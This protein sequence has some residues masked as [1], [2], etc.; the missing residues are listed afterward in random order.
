MSTRKRPRIARLPG[1]PAGTL[2][3]EEEQQREEEQVEAHPSYSALEV[4]RHKDFSE[5]TW[6]EV[7]AAKAALAAM[8]WPLSA[9]PTRRLRSAAGGRQLDL[10]RVIR[11]NLRY[12]GEP[13]TLRW[14]ERKTRCRPLVILCDISGSMERYSRMLLHFLHALS[15]TLGTVETFV[16]GTRLTRI[17]HH[18]RHRDVDDA[19]DEVG[20]IVQDWSGGTKIGQAIKSFNYEW[21]RRVLGRGAVVLIISDGWDRGEVDV[22]AHAIGRLQRAAHRLIWLNP[23]LGSESYEPIQRGMAAAL[24]FVDDF[25]PVHNLKSLEQ[26]AE[27]LSTLSDRRPER[28][29][30]PRLQ[31]ASSS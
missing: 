4:L 20:R 11:D 18:L 21:A 2:S 26:L 13:L 1:L 25:L 5:M 3:L 17:T 22:L 24:P 19:L 31:V 29:Q 14:R 27:V 15:H 28:R 12:G 23:L 30:R 8:R 7:E 9:R 16:F 6:E 10:R